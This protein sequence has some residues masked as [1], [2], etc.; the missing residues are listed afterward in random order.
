MEGGLR[1]AS[2]SIRENRV[3]LVVKSFVVHSVLIFFGLLMIVPFLWML[4]S[5]LK[6]MPQMFIIPPKILPDPVI[7][8]NYMDSWNALPFGG[9][10]LNSFK[11]T[12]INVAATLLTASM[13]G[14]AFAKLKFPGKD[15]IFIAFLATM[16]VP[17]QVTMIPVFI[18]M[19]YL[20]F[21]DNHLSL[22]IPGMLANAYGV[23][24]LRQF[25]KGIP[26]EME[27]SGILDGCNYW[28]IYLNIILPLLKAPLAALGI[29]TFMG[30]W[31]SFL[32]PLIYLNSPEKFTVP[33]LLNQFRGLYITNWELMMAAACLAIIP[34]LFVYIMGQKYIIEGITLTGLKA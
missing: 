4:S 11:I 24:L 32:A 16:M 13:A 19:K 8:S 12:I 25:I 27:E 30:N 14:F 34:V 18:I 7:W 33:L 31:N 17:F 5:S 28:Q 9:A 2:Q 15:I 29:F 26:A 22:I 3:K 20:N 21:L 10:Y 6:D 23:F 1:V